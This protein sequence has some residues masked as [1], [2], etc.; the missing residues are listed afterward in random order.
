MSGPQYL[1]GDYD[2]GRDKFVVTYGAKFNFGAYKPSGLHAPSATPDGEG[3]LVAIFNMNHGKPTKDWNQIMSL[4]RHLTVDGDDLY[5]VPVEAL[6]S[7]REAPTRFD[8]M[9]LPANQEVVLPALEGGNT[10]EFE[11]EIDTDASPMVEM[12]VL[13]SPDRE[14]FTRIAFYR[15]RGFHGKSLLSVDSSYAST[16]SDVLSRAPETAPL[17]LEEDETLKLRVF[18]DRSVVEVFANGRQ[19][20]ALRVYPDRS[21]STGV[22]FRSQGVDSRILSLQAYRMKS[23]WN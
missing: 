4:P 14:E 5:Q 19:C 17:A 7:L 22:S 15:G 23:I 21:D 11:V 6:K 1:I 2:T 3:G 13:R 9:T 18:V 16:A 8:A 12:N 10:M 20:V